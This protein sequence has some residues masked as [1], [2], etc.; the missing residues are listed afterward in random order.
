MPSMHSSG[1]IGKLHPS[2]EA[3]YCTP[4][5]ERPLAAMALPAISAGEVQW[6]TA[7]VACNRRNDGRQREDFR[8]LS[9]QLGV[10]AQATGSARVQ[11]GETDVIVGVKVRGMH[12]AR[13][14]CRRRRRCRLLPEQAALPDQPPSTT[15]HRRRSAH[16]TQT[17]PTAGGCCLAWSAP[18]WP[19]PR[20]GSAPLPACGGR[21]AAAAGAHRSWAGVRCEPLPP[22]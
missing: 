14:R 13:R 3:L 12:P 17:G 20:S 16:P 7:G 2:A 1:H 19:A 21:T 6:I 11:L 15:L 18:R 22:G 4:R 5:V 9:V 10:I 8:P